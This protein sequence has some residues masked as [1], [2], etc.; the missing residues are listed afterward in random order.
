MIRTLCLPDEV[1]ELKGFW[2]EIQIQHLKIQISVCRNNSENGMSC[3]SDQ[4]IKDYFTKNER[5]LG[6][7]VNIINIDASSSNDKPFSNKLSSFYY[8]MDINLEKRYE[9]YLKQTDIS[10]T[11]GLIFQ[12]TRTFSTIQIDKLKS[13]IN[14][15]RPDANLI[16]CLFF[17]TSDLNSNIARKY[18]DLQEACG[19]MSGILNFLM[20]AG[21]ILANFE[22]NFRITRDNL[23]T[24]CI[25]E[26]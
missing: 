20:L 2:D 23:K 17:F 12:D 24:L 19:T 11:D 16:G 9:I 10:T 8:S 22:N 25:S 26:P 6:F 15:L 5:L 21:M 13:D 18:Q 14:T 4:I 3:Y 7:Y 1:Y